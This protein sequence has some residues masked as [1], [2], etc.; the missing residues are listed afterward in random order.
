MDRMENNNLNYKSFKLA[1]VMAVMLGCL[2]FS[3]SSFLPSKFKSDL[4]ILVIQQSDTKMDAY[5]AAQSAEYLSGILAK[6]IYTDSFIEDTLNQESFENDSNFINLKNSI[7]AESNKRKEI[8]ENM[9]EARNVNNTGIIEIETFNENAEQAKVLGKAIASNLLDNGKNYHGGGESIKLKVVDG[10]NVSTKA[11]YPN[12]WANFGFGFILGF[13][14]SLIMSYFFKGY[15]NAFFKPEE[16]ETDRLKDDNKIKFSDSKTIANHNYANP[17]EQL[18]QSVHGSESDSMVNFEKNQ[19][20]EIYLTN[21]NIH[22]PSGYKQDFEKID[23]SQANKKYG[24]LFGA[25]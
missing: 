19:S 3:L 7:S 10:P 12:V 23:H 2:V 21:E 14:G 11:K 13:I 8:W 22:Y 25:I 20:K 24:E 18:V 4:S 15:E 17:K 9:I 5:S 6:V 16:A 1:I